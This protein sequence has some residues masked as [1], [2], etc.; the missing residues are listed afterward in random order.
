MDAFVAVLAVAVW[1]LLMGPA[2]LVVF[3]SAATDPGERLAA[4]DLAAVPVL[5]CAEPV[6]RAA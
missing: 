4:P 2:V 6:T 5:P 3:A 1:L